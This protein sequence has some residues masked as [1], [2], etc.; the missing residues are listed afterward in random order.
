MR[1]TVLIFVTIAVYAIFL[2]QSAESGTY[3]ETFTSIDNPGS[4]TPGNDTLCNILSLL[5]LN[6]RACIIK[7]R[8]LLKEFHLDASEYDKCIEKCLYLH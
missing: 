5:P 8:W 6:L 1:S 2:L 3:P 4:A 7:C